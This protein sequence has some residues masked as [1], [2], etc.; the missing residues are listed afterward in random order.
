[1][2]E[3]CGMRSTPS[4]PSLPGS[5]WPKLVAPDRVVSMGYIELN[6]G[7]LSLLFYAL[8]LCNYANKQ[9]FRIELF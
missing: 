2:L 8:K 3:L 5:L 9:L 1:M 7:F 4:L 6:R